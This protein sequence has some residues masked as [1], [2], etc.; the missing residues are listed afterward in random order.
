MRRHLFVAAADGNV[1]GLTTLL[2][3]GVLVDKRDRFGR[4]ALGHAANEGKLEAVQFL[5]TRG[6]DPNASDARGIT[7][8]MLAA[9]AA[10]ASRCVYGRAKADTRLVRALLASGA[11]VHARDERGRTALFYAGQ[12][13][14]PTL[15]AAG[16]EV[17]VQDLEGLT[18]LM[19]VDWNTELAQTLLDHGADPTLQD[20]HGWTA[21]HHALQIYRC[22][23]PSPEER[24]AEFPSIRE[25]ALSAEGWEELVLLLIRRGVPVDAHGQGIGTAL[26]LAARRGFTEVAWLLLEYGRANPNL[27]DDEGR[28][29]LMHAAERDYRDVVRLLLDFGADPDAQDRQGETAASLCE[30][31][32][33]R[34]VLFMLTNA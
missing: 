24:L 6:A 34:D 3:N 26:S 25:R 1:D 29:P 2:G 30:R 19:A 23:G 31:R 18:P 10:S 9:S 8:L 7:P 4:T 21:L 33:Q 16:A 32:G 12:E 14:I 28:T 27:R 11:D 17:N 22:D 13:V 15:V 5:L 20:V